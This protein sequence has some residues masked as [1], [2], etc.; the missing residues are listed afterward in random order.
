MKI[1]KRTLKVT[2]VLV[3]KVEHH[4][5]FDSLKAIEEMIADEF[6]PCHGTTLGLK[7]KKVKVE[8]GE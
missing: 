6:C 7:A 2:M 3:E 5:R 4:D 8:K 1:K